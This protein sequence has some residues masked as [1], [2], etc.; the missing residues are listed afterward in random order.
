MKLLLTDV[1]TPRPDKKSI[2]MYV[3]C[4]FQALPH[5]AEDA[6]PAPLPPPAEAIASDDVDIAAV[7]VGPAPSSA[8]VVDRQLRGF[9]YC[10]QEP[11]GAAEEGGRASRPLSGATTASAELG[12]Y[13]AA[14]EDVLAW[15]LEAE[16]RLAAQPPL[17]APDAAGP[18]TPDA[19]AQ[20]HELKEHFH[21]HEVSPWSPHLSPLRIFNELS[22]IS[23]YP[24]YE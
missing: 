24:S 5:S 1:H 22:P 7:E 15:L 4:L 10:E 6:P 19:P 17:H 21:T 9:R 12:G 14:L 20:L 18:D 13:G 16:E 8:G 11:S 3:M 23:V 2:M